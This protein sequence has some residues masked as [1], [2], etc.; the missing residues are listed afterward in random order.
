MLALCLAG[1]ASASIVGSVGARDLQTN[2][3]EAE[4]DATSARQQVALAEGSVSAAEQRHAASARRARPLET[5]AEGATAA[6]RQLEASLLA[7]Q[8]AAAKRVSRLEAAHQREVDD[9]DEEVRNGV[10][11]GLAALVA[12]GLALGW[13]RL[14]SSA[15]ITRLGDVERAQAFGLLIGG[16]FVLI[17][18][19]V[20]LGGATGIV[21]ALGSLLFCLG[22]ILPIALLLAR[23]S[24]AVGSGRE[25]PLLGR[26]RLP[27]W[28]PLATAGLMLILFVASTGSA[29][30][31][32]EAASEPVS[33]QLR[34]EA[35][36]L[37]V[38]SGA[39]ELAAAEARAASLRQVAA[40]PLAQ[41]GR[42]RGA[43]RARRAARRRAGAASGRSRRAPVDPASEDG[44]GARR[45]RR[46]Q[47]CRTRSE[48]SRRSGRGRRRR[49]GVRMPSQLQR[50]SRSEL[51]RLRLRRRQWRR[52]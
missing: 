33:P 52:P 21:G 1:L 15:A 44:G 9:R 24:A 5:A 36:A 45:T 27:G 7:E 40:G 30:F 49:T 50:L 8:R 37:S 2:L 41:P 20:L 3:T 17:V 6:A 10:G 46:H 19:G 47:A 29:L 48:G 28:I 16:G 32:D 26:G 23:H 34:Q 22:F 42:A 43:G 38:G 39:R 12:A 18:A 13:G 4:A 11:F 14:R 31:A 51:P 35:R 25:K